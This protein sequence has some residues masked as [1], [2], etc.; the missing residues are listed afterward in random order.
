MSTYC[1]RQ[2]G[3]SG[4]IVRAH[5]CV[6]DR[7]SHFHQ[8]PHTANVTDM[9]ICVC[10]YVYVCY[11]FTSTLLVTPTQIP[12]LMSTTVACHAATSHSLLF[13]AFQLVPVWEMCLSQGFDFSV[14][15]FKDLIKSSAVAQKYSL[16]V[17]AVFLLCISETVGWNKPPKTRSI[18]VIQLSR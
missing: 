7:E 10:V 3:L 11:S 1:C 15:Y 13:S 2:W 4:C 8:V 5:V 6:C 18:F 12:H 14:L 17:I 9:D 16:S